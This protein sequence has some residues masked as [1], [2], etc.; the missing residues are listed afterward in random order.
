M[1]LSA[2]CDAARLKRV[3]DAALAERAAQELL[4]D[5]AL[6]ERATQELLADKM[7]TNPT[8]S[9]ATKKAKKGKHKT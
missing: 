2:A 4:A 5:A 9:S 7:A 1:P 3:F 6:A 8:G